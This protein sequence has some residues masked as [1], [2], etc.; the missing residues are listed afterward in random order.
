MRVFIAIEIPEEI[1]SKIFHLSENIKDSGVVSG[2]FVE[3]S[4][5]HLTLKFLGDISEEHLKEI[6]DSLDKIQF[7]K[8][9]AQVGEL[10][11]FPN[12]SY[13]KV[14]HVDLK[15]RGNEIMDLHRLI[16]NNLIN[17]K[18]IKDDREFSTHIT[19]ARVKNIR[20]KSL[21]TEKIKKLNLKKQE[22]E[23]DRFSIIKSEL[24]RQGP[25]YKKIKEFKLK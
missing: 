24:T 20:N 22:F 5:L 3:K 1:Q 9:N 11:F 25:V 14:I 18:V 10:G 13:V 12:E 8:F 17:A 19:L 16:E 7:K 21:F 6:V 4:N 15:S 23:V 2:N